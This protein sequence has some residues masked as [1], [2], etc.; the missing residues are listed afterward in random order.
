M[1]G[2]DSST[3][4]K[5]NSEHLWETIEKL[6]NQDL[7]KHKCCK[8]VKTARVR[9]ANYFLYL[10]YFKLIEDMPLLKYSLLSF[11]LPLFFNTSPAASFSN[12]G[13]TQLMP[14]CGLKMLK[15]KRNR[16]SYFK[17]I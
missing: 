13:E 6:D 14:Y 17:K 1:V 8:G 10:P 3:E 15:L 11:N 4:C 2:F 5:K 9:K 7:Y 16:C 12:T